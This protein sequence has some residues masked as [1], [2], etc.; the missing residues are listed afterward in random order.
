VDGAARLSVLHE[1][2]LALSGELDR[3]RLYEGIVQGARRLLGAPISMFF[4][5]DP[6]REL[7]VS[8]AI[9]GDA[10]PVEIA[11]ADV[12][13]CIGPAYGEKTTVAAEELG[14]RAR[15]PAFARAL[16]LRAA[17][18][19]PLVNQGQVTGVLFVADTSRPAF[20]AEEVRLVELLAGHVALALANAETV[21]TAAR[22][23]ARAEELGA[24]LRGI[25]DAHDRETIVERA[26]DC[27]TTVLGADRGA[28]YVADDRLDI[29]YVA[30]RRLS[31]PYLDAVARHYRRSVGGIA[32][33]TRTP[34][35]VSDMAT[36]PRTRVLHDLARREGLRAMLLVPLIHR[37]ELTGA[38][39]V[40]HDVA[41]SYTGDDIAPVRALADQLALCLASAALQ[42]QK[43]RQLAQLRVLDQIAR[44]LARPIDPEAAGSGVAERCRRGAQAI[45]GAGGALAAWI[46][47]PDGHPIA[48]AGAST[49]DGQSIARAA[50]EAR[51]PVAEGQ[52]VAAPVATATQQ[53]GVLVL[54]PVHPP[55]PEARP[56]TVHVTLVEE[57]EISLDSIANTAAQ[58]GVYLANA[59]L[60]AD[61]LVVSTR[62]AAVVDCMP[63]AV[64]VYDRNDR[65]IL[66]NNKM[67]E[68]WG[69][70]PSTDLHGWTPDDFRKRYSD[71]VRD[72][73]VS[74]EIVRLV[75][76][77]VDAAQRHK[78][79]IIAPT[80][81][82][83]ERLVTPVKT[84][85]GQPI[86]QVVVYHDLTDVEEKK[87]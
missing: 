59:R 61:A 81:R 2:A 49:L 22:R 55:R 47:G 19:A 70:D 25:T 10:P 38:L 27:A 62:L 74:S 52:L 12:P 58:I 28:V 85:S 50:L 20:T 8:E 29:V 48:S 37:G 32:S 53:F 51:A 42:K 66:Y 75:T 64:L 54:Q 40:Y 14:G 68:L 73:K 24:S 33:L 11:P 79:E 63:D 7:L 83:V 71:R 30:G 43:E 16:G 31:R 13:Y 60:V 39:S 36:D 34:I 82:W 78:F 23:L 86:G 3:T 15:A 6:G 56:Q 77:H 76:S 21:T 65:V 17:V 45:V 41:W 46:F 9:S 69:I 44:A 5:W 72:S 35:Y 57:A 67:L 18:A 26:L 84:E 4:T 1:I 80:R 87:K